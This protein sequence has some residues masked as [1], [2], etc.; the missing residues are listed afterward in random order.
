MC[1]KT[2]DVLAHEGNSRKEVATWTIGPQRVVPPRPPQ[3]A[4]RAG[5]RRCVSAPVQLRAWPVALIRSR[6]PFSSIVRCP[7]L[8]PR[9]V[10]PPVVVGPQPVGAVHRLETGPRA[11]DLVA[12][13]AT[14]R[15][16]GTK[17]ETPATARNEE[18]IA[19]QTRPEATRQS[20]V[21][22]DPARLTTARPT[23]NGR[24]VASNVTNEKDA[25]RAVVLIGAHARVAPG[26][27]VVRRGHHDATREHRRRSAMAPTRRGAVHVTVIARTVPPATVDRPVRAV[28]LTRGPKLPGRVRPATRTALIE[29]TATVDRPAPMS[30]VIGGR[31][32]HR[33]GAD[34]VRETQELVASAPVEAIVDHA[35]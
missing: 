10:A 25:I 17:V 31:V 28:A 30:C 13:V 19:A 5:G 18:S 15:A 33:A 35:T 14:A 22:P 2:M 8:N 16:V 27:M 34:P 21:R 29:V 6:V 9:P 3:N 24:R 23:V 12:T 20:P 11:A 1:K 4:R 7:H 26:A 32:C